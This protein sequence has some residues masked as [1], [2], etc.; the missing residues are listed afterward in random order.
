MTR[1]EPHNGII[2]PA[3]IMT[4]MSTLLLISAEGQVGHFDGAEKNRETE[5]GAVRK[6]MAPLSIV[7]R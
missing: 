3:M 6:V 4:N 1:M 5:K 7:Q 2:L